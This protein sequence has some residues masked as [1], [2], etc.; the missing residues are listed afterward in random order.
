MA[1][2]YCACGWIGNRSWCPDCMGDT[3]IPTRTRSYEELP[4]KPKPASEY[5]K[6]DDPKE[7]PF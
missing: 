6:F 3:G 2:N 7:T 1:T 5:E 4:P